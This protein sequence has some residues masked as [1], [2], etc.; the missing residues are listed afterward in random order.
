M[1]QE[2]D[3]LDLAIEAFCTELGVVGKSF[4]SNRTSYRGISD[5]KEGVQWNI[6]KDKGFELIWLGVNLEGMKY[7]NWPIADFIGNELR[8]SALIKIAQKIED[9]SKIIVGL[10]R[11]AWQFTSRPPIKE[12]IIGGDR[13]FPLSDLTEIKWKNMLTEALSCLNKEKNYRGR[14]KQIV[15]L[16]N[17]NIKEMEVSPHLNIH[18][19]VAENTSVSNANVKKLIKNSFDRLRPIYNF[20]KDCVSTRAEF[21][22]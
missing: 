9:P 16:S 19:Q 6:W 1:V 4:G 12:S 11:D 22:L 15:T 18:T 8:E 17:N 10:H 20:V 7:Y 5:G 13:E 3:S 14:A 21:N 2:L